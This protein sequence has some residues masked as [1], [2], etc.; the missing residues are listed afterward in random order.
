MLEPKQFRGS[1]DLGSVLYVLIKA[2]YKSSVLFV[3]AAW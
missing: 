3:T 2:Q 1:I